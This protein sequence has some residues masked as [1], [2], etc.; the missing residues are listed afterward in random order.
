MIVR[1]ETIGGVALTLPRRTLHML[2]GS[3]LAGM[4]VVGIPGRERFIPPASMAK[5]P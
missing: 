2:P 5:N 4:G 1:H 3:P